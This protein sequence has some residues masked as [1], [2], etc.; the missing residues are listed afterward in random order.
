MTEALPPAIL[1]G[2]AGMSAA[3][4][5]AVPVDAVFPLEQASAAIGAFTR[6]KRGKIVLVVDAL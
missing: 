4:E 2:L 5:L 1:S 3:G 6:G